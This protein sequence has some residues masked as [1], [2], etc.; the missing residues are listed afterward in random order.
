MPTLNTPAARTHLQQRTHRPFRHLVHRHHR[1]PRACAEVLPV[2]IWRLVPLSCVSECVPKY[3][4]SLNTS[5]V[6][7]IPSVPMSGPQES[8]SSNLK[9]FPLLN[10]MLPIKLIQCAYHT[11][12][13]AFIPISICNH[14]NTNTL[15]TI[16]SCRI[17]KSIIIV[18]HCKLN[19]SSTAG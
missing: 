9:R 1:A 3:F 11:G 12:R 8:P 15:Q 13:G 18:V 4:S 2:L 16:K 14:N 7:N 17:T 5:P 19:L 6:K 10:D